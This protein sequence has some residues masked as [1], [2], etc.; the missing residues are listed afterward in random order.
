MYVAAARSA[1]SAT[2]IVNSLPPYRKSFALAPALPAAQ[3]SVGDRSPAYQ[4]CLSTC[5]SACPSIPTSKLTLWPCAHD[6]R[7]TCLT[8][9]TD[10]A[11]SSSQL[12]RALQGKGG[13]LEGLPIGRMVQFNGKW[14]FHRMASVQEPLSVLFSLANLWAHW[15]GWRDLGKM[16]SGAEGLRKAVF[17]TRD[18]DWTEKAD[19]FSAAG[20]MLCG[21]WIAGVRLGGLYGSAGAGNGR[22]GP[23]S[24]IR[25]GWA[26]LCSTIFGAHC[27]YL[28]KGDRFDYGYN[29][30]FNVIVALAQIFLWAAWSA[31]HQFI[32]PKPS[33]F[34]SVHPSSSSKPTRASHSHLPLLPLLLLP[35]LTALELLDFAP[36]GPFGL[37]MLDAHALWHLSTVAVV[38]MWYGFLEKDLRW[39]EGY[40]GA[41]EEVEG[42]R[43]RVE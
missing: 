18:V 38:R 9:L 12:D 32:L 19:Y 14:P 36:I 1:V 23:R 4:R 42:G 10:L 25:R 31:Y 15:R 13:V 16:G 40:S 6:C 24:A 43:S 2:Y 26:L 5:I 37:R 34:L 41:S 20:G 27:L 3:A 22:R 35:A 8:F 21:L 11:L 30:R 17:H 39:V 28:A 29:M 7:Y 33:P